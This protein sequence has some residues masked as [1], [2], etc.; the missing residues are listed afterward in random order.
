MA[1]LHSRRIIANTLVVAGIALFAGQ[2]LSL[3]PT[4]TGD[5][6]YVFS[7]ESGGGTSQDWVHPLWVPLLAGFRAV[8]GAF[9]WHGHMLVPIEI[10]NIAFGAAAIVVMYRLCRRVVTDPIAAA[11]GALLLMLCT[12]F[13]MG[14]LRTT[15]YAPAFLC[16]LSS[17]ALLVSG[18]AVAPRRYALAGLFAGL[19]TGLHAGGL[20]LLPAAGATSLFE[21]CETGSP[22]AP[23]LKAF[24]G[25]MGVTVAACVLVFLWRHP[26]FIGGGR[27]VTAIIRDAEQV[28]GTSI[29]TSRS[30]LRQLSL[31]ASV[32]QDDVLKYAVCAL[33]ALFP[34]RRALLRSASVEQR[35]I[36]RRL[37]CVAAA[38][39][40][41]MAG[42]FIIN[43]AVNGFVFAALALVPATIA[44]VAGRS[45]YALR[46]LCWVAVPFLILE[47]VHIGWGE[48]SDGGAGLLHEVRFAEQLV[49][50][51]GVL[52]TPGCPFPEVRYFTTMETYFVHQ[53]GE[54]PDVSCTVPSLEAGADAAARIRSWIAQGRPV[55]L[56][57]G[58]QTADFSVLLD[59]G[60]EKETQLFF[61]ADLRPEARARRI[62]AL[63]AALRS[64]GIGFGA[65]VASPIAYRDSG[66]HG[67]YV[68]LVADAPRQADARASA[69]R[70]VP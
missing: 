60:G 41:G 49:S 53:A 11:C 44:I 16:V 55:H 21:R 10:L 45:P 46:N 4:D 9:G 3:L 37:V 18:T 36:E 39:F 69:D 22:V 6:C 47:S 32:M 29:Y 12:T 64:G 20:A 58:N 2:S 61:S 34:V 62:A 66:G 57:L 68:Q 19:A 30:W 28:P 40:A 65:L 35:H 5:L 17:G 24:A 52:L 26:E 67:E 43:N 13:W 54:S 50:P 33:V 14:T 63:Q 31:Y 1:A 59:V 38:I 48:S 70:E 51:N 7:V 23:R 27:G 56:A 8:L 42:F 25:T 15:P